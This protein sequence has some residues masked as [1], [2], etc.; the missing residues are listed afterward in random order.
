[1]S[2]KS[3]KF[4]LPN[5]GSYFKSS[6]IETKQLGTLHCPEMVYHQTCIQEY[7]S[8]SCREMYCPE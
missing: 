2:Q 8:L 3:P 4:G 1:M 7:T 5:I 6:V